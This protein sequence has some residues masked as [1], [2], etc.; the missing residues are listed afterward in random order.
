MLIF[1]LFPFTFKT[2]FIRLSIG[3]IILSIIFTGKL[4]IQLFT[5]SEKL[6]KVLSVMSFSIASLFNFCTTKLKKFS[7]WFRTGLLDGI[8]N[9]SPPIHATSRIAVLEFCLG[10]PFINNLLS[11]GFMLFLSEE[12]K[13]ESTISANLVSV[14]GPKYFWHRATPL[15]NETPTIKFEFIDPSFFP[16]TV[17]P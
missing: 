5:R 1:N 17:Q 16:L 15:L 6:W 7:M 8:L 9:T 3:L 12:S 4:S 10:H 11:T 2:M 13:L 14:I